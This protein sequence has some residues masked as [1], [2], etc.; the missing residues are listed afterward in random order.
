MSEKPNY[1]IYLELTNEINNIILERRDIEFTL[2]LIAKIIDG[3]QKNSEISF[4]RI[5]YQ[6]REYKSVEYS[7][8]GVCFE[9]KFYGLNGEEGALQICFTKYSE[10]DFEKDSA[11]NIFIGN[12][13]DI[14]SGYFSK[15]GKNETS[16]GIVE[17]T[18]Y[19]ESSTISLKFLQRFLNK[20]THNRDIYHDLMPFKVKEILL[21][22]SL[23]DAYAIDREG[24][25][26]EHMLGQYM[27]LNLTSF[28]RI[29]GASSSQQ[30]F[31]I[32]E[33]KQF[34]LV[35]YMVGANKK[36]PLVTSRQIKKRYPYL[37]IYL[38][39]NNSSDI[40]YYQEI[41]DDF[42]FAD[43]IFSWNGNSNIFFSMIKLLED[44]INVFNDTE[45]GNVRV[46]LLVEDNPTYYSRYLSF[47][48]KVLMEQTKR[49]IDD[50]STDEL[51]KVLRMRA[52][53]KI[54]LATNYEEAVQI[55]K[56]HKK[57]LL[58]LIT[59]VKFNMKGKS[60]QAA[61]IELIKYTRKQIKNLPTVIQSSDLMNK[62][63]AHE[64]NSL[65]IYK[66]SETLYLDFLDF[67]T[68]NL[69]FGDFIFKDENENE[70]ARASN[71][72]EFERLIKTIPVESLLFH[73]SRDHLSMWL[74]ARGEIRAANKL[75]PKK[76]SDFDNIDDLRG[77]ILSLIR[78]YRSEKAT[79]NVIPYEEG[80]SID[81]GNVYSLAEGSM[82][83]K[84]R[85]LAFINA[86]IGNYNFSK[87]IPDIEIRTPKT[88]IIRTSEFENFINSNK[89]HTTIL[90]EKDYNKIRFAFLQGHL[91][92]DLKS[93]LR[94]ILKTFTKP[95]AVRS[96]GLFEDSISQ[97]FAG[98]FETYLLPNSHD[99]FEIR[100]QQTLDAIKLVFASVF[101]TTAK[102]YV[103]AISYK[104]EDEKMAVVLQE[105]V[106]NQYDNLYYPHISGVALS[107]NYY[108]IAHMKPEEG[109][110]VAAV[111]LGK[112]VVEGQKA[113]RF[114]PKY[115][116]IEIN[117]PKNQFKNSQVQ[118]YAIDLERKNLNLFEGEMAGL[119]HE[120]ISVAEKQGTLN[121]CA[122]VYNPDSN[123]I[124]PGVK[125][126]GPRI[127]N[128]ANILKYNYIPLHQTLDLVL[129]LGRDAMGSAI[130]I[131]Y[132][133]DLKKDSEGRASFYILQ[134][135]PLINTG[136]DCNINMA[137]VEK[138]SI[139][140]YTEKGMGNGLI[141]NVSNII[142]LDPNNF[143]KSKTEEMVK[144][145]EELNS[146]MISQNKKYVLIG[147]GRW[148]TRDKWIGIPVNWY[149]ISNA[150]V[151]VETSLDNFPLDASSGSHFFH[152]VTSMDVGYFTVQSEITNSYIT[153]N[154]L[155]EQNLIRK[156]QFFNIVEF[157]KPLTIKMDGKKR[158][159]LIHS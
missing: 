146:F 50:V 72:N 152:N 54:L 66:N 122:S 70:I 33:S 86:L 73:G 140:L 123:T 52:R 20:N 76:V 145:I 61:G 16:K 32:L 28:P 148:G 25:F 153:Y 90:K 103:E 112:Y 9:N 44:Q 157:E 98:I 156:G 95:I 69:G 113:F 129:N 2:N 46:I 99:D 83:G 91:S 82:G 21:I 104:L 27:D 17:E 131:E 96:S 133:V 24:R 116:G 144:E 132:A 49:I 80:M 29:T 26:S 67:I 1:L 107:F 115:P 120:D 5:L 59:D 45:I 56:A 142:Y 10:E 138:D 22:S 57:Y 47:L 74:M 48:Y 158:I 128:F 135:K 121:H 75:I 58:C 41:E 55:I 151:I 130:E 34:D 85:G 88:I 18:E 31:E 51:Y 143:D 62:E 78:A 7:S 93:K 141:D 64:I 84:G 68:N 14:I 159:Y 117:S 137:E 37:P 30:A 105:V 134:I 40:A 60:E 136:V 100:L 102:G 97:P 94:S 125:K 119:S 154:L 12:I 106:G 13:A 6:G 111:G 71:I 124:Y 65:F 139:V 109:F 39:T 149:Q 42:N 114:S 87:F 15:I 81:E 77:T 53:P 150:K 79:G 23:Y 8:M 38:L 89:L 19:I 108:P 110:A 63:L 11:K 155:K 3:K 127:V 92:A 126:R 36:M 118:F 101:S 43:K 4:I 35:I 147:P